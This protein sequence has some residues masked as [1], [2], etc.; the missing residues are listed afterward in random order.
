MTRLEKSR[1]LL[2]DYRSCAQTIVEGHRT[3]C[4]PSDLDTS[5]LLDITTAS[6]SFSKY[7]DKNT[8]QIHDSAVY[9]KQLR[10]ELDSK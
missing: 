4:L 10:T 7:V 9:Y 2:G 6:D 8:G 3:S 1:W 5:S